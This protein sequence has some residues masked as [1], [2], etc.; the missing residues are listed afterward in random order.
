MNIFTAFTIYRGNRSDSYDVVILLEVEKGENEH[1]E[2]HPIYIKR[3]VTLETACRVAMNRD[4]L[5]GLPKS[6]G[7]TS[8]QKR[9]IWLENT[10]GDVLVSWDASMGWEFL[11][12]DMTEEERRK[13]LTLL[14]DEAIRDL[15][16][17]WK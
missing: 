12:H 3:S 7:R 14:P 11:D 1:R 15:Q 17:Q 10:N 5:K 9:V 13:F 2:Y 4:S 8:H 16:E 6:E